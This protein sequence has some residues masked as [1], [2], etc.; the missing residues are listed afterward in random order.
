VLL[1]RALD[2]RLERIDT[3][4]SVVEHFA[5]VRVTREILE[6]ATPPQQAIP[7]HLLVRLLREGPDGRVR[8]RALELLALE[9]PLEWQPLVLDSL[10]DPSERVRSGALDVI[11]RMRWTAA[12]AAIQPIALSPRPRLQKRAREV[13]A[14]LGQPIDPQQ[15]R[16]SVLPAAR[17]LAGRLRDA[18]MQYADAF[19]T[20][21]VADDTQVDHDALTRHVEAYLDQTF[22]SASSPHDFPGVLLL[23]VAAQERQDK[24]VRRLWEY[25]VIQ[26]DTEAELLGRGL[27]TL[28]RI[29]LLR[30]LIAYARGDRASGLAAL[31]SLAR[32]SEHA[33]DHPKL[34]LYVRQASELSSAIWGA[35]TRVESGWPVD[36]SSPDTTGRPA[37]PLIQGLDLTDPRDLAEARRRLDA[38][39][40]LTFS[41][42][43]GALHSRQLAN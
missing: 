5:R 27:E 23:A 43:T 19:P 26:T 7:A 35:S 2:E 41:A 36:S 25:E 32:F 30:G 33:R 39:C 24:L 9:P 18:G 22:P 42:S 17:A 38:W 14:L 13:L 21:V 16:D 31:A 40:G 29:R 4:E 28:A 20:A 12:G 11:A 37:T 1:Q 8:A 10:R 6:R 15:E 3:P 34:A